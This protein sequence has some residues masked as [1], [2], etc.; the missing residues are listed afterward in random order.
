MLGSLRSIDDRLRSLLGSAE[1]SVEEVSALVT[2]VSTPEVVHHVCEAL[3]S[4]QAEVC[5]C[6]LET[7]WQEPLHPSPLPTPAWALAGGLLPVACPTLS[8][9]IEWKSPRRLRARRRTGTWLGLCWCG[10]RR[11]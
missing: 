11:Q 7:H 5:E 4:P 1:E 8:L 6:V 2:Y 3:R 9:H 10:W